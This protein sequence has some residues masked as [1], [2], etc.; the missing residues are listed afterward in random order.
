[1]QLGVRPKLIERSI[2]TGDAICGGFL[3]WRTLRRLEG[4]GVTALGGH[5][6]HRVR[7]FAGSRTAEAR[8]PAPGMGVSRH[9]LDT[10]MQAM[11]GAN[12]TDFERGVAVREIHGSR[13]RTDAGEVA[14]EALFLATG[15]HDVRGAARPRDGGDPTVGLRLRLTRNAAL[16]A[17]VGEAIELHLFDRGY[18][19]LLLQEDGGGNLCLAVRKSRL[20]QSGG[21]TA[22]L[23]AEIA[24]GTPLGERMAHIDA[25]PTVDAIAAVPYGWR[26]AETVPAVFRLGDQAA[27]IPSLAGEGIGIAVASG[28]SAADAWAC[29][30]PEAASAYQ[31]EFARRTARPVKIAQALWGLGERP[32]IAHR[33]TLALA[34]APWLVRTAARL[35]RIGD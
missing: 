7:V 20:A 19:G 10:A 34:H 5:A 12:G 11:V 23:I 13:F 31:R 28:I 29:G 1:M 18:I 35:T 8:L 3:S 16:S 2:E 17:L 14:P 27:V 4:L 15:K 6:I 25:T 9:R 22:R 21:S 32:G 24:H 33:A 26:T 30:G